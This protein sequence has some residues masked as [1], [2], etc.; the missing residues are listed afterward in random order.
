VSDG[1]VVEG[2]Y[3]RLVRLAS[4]V[5]ITLHTSDLDVESAYSLWVVIFNNPAGCS[6]PCGN[7][8]L[9]NAAAE[10]S[11]RFGVG[12]LIGQSGKGSFGAHIPAG[13][14]GE[15]LPAAPPP[16]FGPGLLNPLGAEIHLV[17]RTHG[18]AAPASLPEQIASFNGGCPPNTCENRQVSVHKP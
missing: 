15:G 18:P 10:P 5:S 13:N 12:H 16:P 6:E 7:D 1:S 2:A 9:T 17:L 3:S 11:A 14:T 4:G 8:D